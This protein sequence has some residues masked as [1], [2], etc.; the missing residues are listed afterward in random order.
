MYIYIYLD[1]VV[2]EHFLENFITVWISAEL[3][4]TELNHFACVGTYFMDASCPNTDEVIA[5]KSIVAGAKL[6]STQCPLVT[7][8]TFNVSRELECCTPDD[9]DC[10]VMA[11]TNIYH[12][13]CTGKNACTVRPT[14]NQLTPDSC[15]PGYPITTNYLYSTYYCIQSEYI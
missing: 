11:S 13:G 4:E 12:P 5:M 2:I 6:N 15:Q 10:T 9:S 3:T 14:T 7:T 1:H 8:D